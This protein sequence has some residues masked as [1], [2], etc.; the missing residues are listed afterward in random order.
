[1]IKYVLAK[2]P[3]K[4]LQTFSRKKSL[5]VWDTLEEAK[6]VLKPLED[7][8]DCYSRVDPWIVYKIEENVGKKPTCTPVYTQRQ[9]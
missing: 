2:S 5:L 4:A 1:M 7:S 6:G 3:L 8:S 9:E